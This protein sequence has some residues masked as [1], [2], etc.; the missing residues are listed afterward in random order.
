MIKNDDVLLSVR[1]LCMHFGNR[2]GGNDALRDV[3]FDIMR[4]EIFGLVGESGSGKTTT[5]RCITGIYTPTS[6]EVYFNREKIRAGVGAYKRRLNKL[7]VRRRVAFSRLL[8]GIKSGYCGVLEGV[9]AWRKVNKDLQIK[10]KEERMLISEA[11]KLS[12]RRSIPGIQMIFQDP[13]ASLNPRMTVGEIVAEGLIARGV[14]DG[15][16]RDR[17]IDEA[18][19]SVG[20][21]P[22]YRS[23]YPHEFSGGQKQR[24]GIARAVIMRPELLI[25]D[26]PVSALDVSVQAQ[27]INLLLDLAHTLSLSVLF[28][29]HDLSVVRHACD[30]VGVMY[31]GRLVE[32]APTEELFANPA[33]PYTRSLLCAIPRPDPMRERGR[34]VDSHRPEIDGASRSL[35]QISEGHLV[36]ATKE[37]IEAYKRDRGV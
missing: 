2:A 21:S 12:A 4:A 28:I 29:A 14:A 7:K 3:S 9:K 15:E 36:L 22:S 25:A 23:R 13:A 31:R 8:D 26:E 24:I 18:L 32:I 34:H 16:E 1:D 37:E 10:Q 33:H 11:A 35:L 30:R 27:V 20:L 5:G 6:G 19:L 17:M